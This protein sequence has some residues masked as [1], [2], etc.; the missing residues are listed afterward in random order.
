M[1]IIIIATILIPSLI[2]LLNK[3]QN[4][5]ETAEGR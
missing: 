4:D 1:D 2:A 5:Y 3:V